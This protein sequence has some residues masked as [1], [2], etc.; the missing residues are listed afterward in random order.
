MLISSTSVFSKKLAENCRRAAEIAKGLIIADFTAR[1]FERLE[2]F[3]EIAKQVGR[4]LVITPKD[5]YLLNA[6]KKADGINN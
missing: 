1:N 6:L 5:A 3:Q 2:T 4:S